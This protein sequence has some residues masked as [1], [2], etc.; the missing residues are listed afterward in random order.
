MWR[1]EAGGDHPVQTAALG[2]QAGRVASFGAGL[3]VGRVGRALAKKSQG[4]TQSDRL[5]IGYQNTDRVV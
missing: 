1:I 3:L 4:E 2:S 5:G